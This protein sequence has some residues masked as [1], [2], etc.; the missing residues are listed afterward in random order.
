[1]SKIIIPKKSEL[2]N[3]WKG[4]RIENTCV[5]LSR[6]TSCLPIDILL[7]NNGYLPLDNRSEHVLRWAERRS[8][9]SRQGLL[10]Y[11]NNF[12]DK[13]SPN[14]TY[15]TEETTNLV[16]NFL[17]KNN[18]TK[19]SGKHK[20]WIKEGPT[21]RDE[22]Y[23]WWTPIFGGE[24]ISPWEKTHGRTTPEI[25]TTSTNPTK[26]DV[27]SARQAGYYAHRLSPGDGVESWDSF[28]PDAVLATRA[29]SFVY[30][31][32]ISKCKMRWY[33][34]LNCGAE[35]H[36]IARLPASEVFDEYGKQILSNE[37]ILKRMR[38]KPYDGGE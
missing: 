9:K 13:Y 38:V 25:G 26:A 22:F 11:W 17:K 23:G 10:A 32:K 34:D 15:S 5:I 21:G 18:L 1:M 3:A 24:T 2:Q 27:Q 4:I 31:V 33:G 8:G 12:R 36:Y 7:I 20:K 37:E 14:P 16:W 29:D 19:P 6:Y 35:R 30:R 28:M